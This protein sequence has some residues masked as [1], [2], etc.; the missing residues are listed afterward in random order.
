M[1]ESRIPRVGVGDPVGSAK[2]M[3]IERVVPILAAKGYK[4][5]IV[6]MD[7]V[8]WEDADRMRNNLAVEKQLLPQELVVGLATE[9]CPQ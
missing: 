5:G 7:V 6:S 8:S 2:T 3:L 4:I 1:S 9:G